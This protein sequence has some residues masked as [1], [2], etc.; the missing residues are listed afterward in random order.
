MANA[1]AFLALW[2]LPALF[3]CITA[4]RRNDARKEF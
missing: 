3:V 4:E 2:V 1:L